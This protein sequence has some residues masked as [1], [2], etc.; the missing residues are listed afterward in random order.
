MNPSVGNR[1]VWHCA[2]H[3]ENNLLKELLSTLAQCS[4]DS[5]VPLIHLTDHGRTL[6]IPCF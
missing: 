5:Q 1:C 4:D 6:Q 3:L 2:G